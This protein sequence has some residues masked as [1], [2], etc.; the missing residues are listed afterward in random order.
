MP[1]PRP[2]NGTSSDRVDVLDAAAPAKPA[3]SLIPLPLYYRSASLLL[4]QVRTAP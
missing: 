3:N 2:R 1:A 4:Q